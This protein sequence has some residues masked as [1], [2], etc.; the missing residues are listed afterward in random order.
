MFSLI[1]SYLVCFIAAAFFNWNV[2]AAELF[3]SINL[4]GEKRPKLQKI[5]LNQ[6]TEK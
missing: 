6:M 4:Y 2:G 3:Y 5:A 1:K